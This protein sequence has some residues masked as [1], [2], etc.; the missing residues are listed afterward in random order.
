MNSLAMTVFNYTKNSQTLYLIL[1]LK[2]F[3]YQLF[4]VLSHI[5]IL[6]LKNL[7]ILLEGI[8]ISYLL[9]L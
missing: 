7:F 3:K 9:L 2:K 6:T 1:V 4:E 8:V 5:T